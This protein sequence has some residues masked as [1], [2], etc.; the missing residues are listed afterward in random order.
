MTPTAVVAIPTKGWHPFLK[1]IQPP[2]E[3]LYPQ[4]RVFVADQKYSFPFTFVIPDQLLPTA[5]RHPCRNESLPEV[6]RQLPPSLGDPGLA[7]NGAQLLDDLA[8]TMSKITYHIKVE[9]K[10]QRLSD[11]KDIVVSDKREKI[12]II[13]AV[14]EM[15]PLMIDTKN[16]DYVTRKEKGLKKGLLKGKMGR[17]SLEAAQP[18][19]FR[20]PPPGSR[21]VCPATTMAV[22]V[23]RFD[24][25]NEAIMPPPLA[26]VDARLRVATYFSSSPM[27]DFPCHHSA[28]YDPAQGHYT[29]DVLLSSR[30]I[31]TAK[32]TR[33]EAQDQHDTDRR[34]STLSI[35]SFSVNAP[36]PEPSSA[37]AGSSFYV[38]RV[39]VPLSLPKDKAWPPTFSSCLVSR[40][41]AL[42]LKASVSTPSS[43][44]NPTL[45]LVLPVQISQAGDMC[46]PIVQDPS[47]VTGPP[48]PHPASASR[49]ASV[50]SQAE[51]ESFFRPRAVVGRRSSEGGTARRSTSFTASPL[52]FPPLTSQ[53]RPHPPSPSSIPS[54]R[55]T[56]IE[57]SHAAIADHNVGTSAGHLADTAPPP[58]YSFFAGASHGVPVRIPSPRG[59][60]PGCG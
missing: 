7:S 25:A 59:F 42:E 35:S 44:P 18:K 6:H 22:L 3:S 20:L 37:Y 13:P 36:L 11:G 9:V 45:T 56:V 40:T 51:V 28:V 57:G 43:R 38:A 12:R 16:S 32:W 33:F 17:L 55:T 48:P 34:D 15:P 31:E 24:P 41:Y 47:D 52:S 58:G 39:L 30:G 53:T 50:V 27:R 23:L 14:D 1:L 19:S 54:P 10:R 46:R 8:P 26:H 60:S 29:K 2:D 5:C 21:P 4:P 49:N